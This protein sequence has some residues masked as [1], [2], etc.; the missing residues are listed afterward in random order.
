MGG[1]QYG[2][3]GDPPSLLV[4][5]LNRSIETGR[6]KAPSLLTGSKVFAGRRGFF[7][8]IGEIFLK[9]EMGLIKRVWTGGSLLLNTRNHNRR[10]SSKT[11]LSMRGA[12]SQ[13]ESGNYIRPI[14]NLNTNKKRDI[15]GEWRREA[16]RPVWRESWRGVLVHGR[17][18]SDT[19]GREDQNRG[20]SPAMDHK[21]K[22]RA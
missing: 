13:K 11:A 16:T 10:H 2:E 6:K 22:R 1:R 8:D 4:K 15:D 12:K 18:R 7:E 21:K 20:Q 19:F 5:R 14:Y 3:G 17:A 9:I